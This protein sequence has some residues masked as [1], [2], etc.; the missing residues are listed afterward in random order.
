MSFNIILWMVFGALAGW[1]ANT[2]LKRNSEMG[3]FANIF[4]GIIGA[5]VGGLLMNLLGAGGVS[6]F[7][8]YNLLVAIFSAVVLLFLVGMMQQSDATL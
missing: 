8:L 5:T 7:N 1:T 2:I 4:L 6:G 3:A